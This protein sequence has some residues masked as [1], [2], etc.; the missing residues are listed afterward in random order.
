M[1][2]DHYKINLNN[3]GSAVAYPKFKIKHNSDNGWCGIVKSQTENYEIGNPEEA[4]G[5]N[6]KNSEVLLDYTNGKITKAF[7]DGTKNV[8][9]LNTT[10][11]DIK[12]ELFLDE[13]WGQSP[14]CSA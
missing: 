2:N 3:L 1:T 12:G 14:P 5:K 9:I 6:V 4:D 7:Q 11:Q 10:N 13:A 8:A